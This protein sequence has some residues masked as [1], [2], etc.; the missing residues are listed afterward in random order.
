MTPRP[1]PPSPTCTPVWR[2]PIGNEV[3]VSYEPHL[4]D[5]VDGVVLALPHGASSRS[6]P[7][8]STG[9]GWVIDLAADFRHTDAALYDDW[10]GEPHARPDL[11]GTFTYGL[12]ELY[13]DRAPA[14]DAGRVARLLPDRGHPRRRAARAGRA[15]RP[16]PGHRRRRV[17][18]VGRR[19][20]G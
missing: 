4:L 20:A 14:L 18:R 17:G 3:F 2:R 9:V 5:G 10:Y 11:L 6:W 15:R 19:S 7:T 13:R 8:S 1:A 12:P 16:V